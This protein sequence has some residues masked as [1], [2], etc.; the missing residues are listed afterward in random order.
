MAI[1]I[2]VWFYCSIIIADHLVVGT[3][4]GDFAT[5]FYYKDS[6]STVYNMKI[7]YLPRVEG[8]QNYTYIPPFTLM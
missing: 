3:S 5:T 7:K 2:G 8:F 4:N 6:T 1:V